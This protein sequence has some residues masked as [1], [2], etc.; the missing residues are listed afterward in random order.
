MLLYLKVRERGRQIE[1]NEERRKTKR[2]E[3]H[4][5]G[6]NKLPFCDEEENSDDQGKKRKTTANQSDV[7]QNL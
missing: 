5:K 3:S 2:D 4:P 7:C 6:K 1:G